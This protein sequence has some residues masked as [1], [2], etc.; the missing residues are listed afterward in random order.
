MNKKETN[1]KTKRTFVFTILSCILIFCIGTI[2]YNHNLIEVRHYN[3]KSEKIGES[4]NNY[5]IVQLSDLH[6]RKFGEDN[7]RVIKY[8]D[9]ENPN[10]VV[11]TGDMVTREEEKYDN[12][13][14]LAK[15]ISEKYETY[16]ILGNHEQGLKSIELKNLLFRVKNETNVS[17]I[18]NTFVEIKREEESINLYG[19]WYSKKYYTDLQ[20]KRLTKEVIEKYI[21]KVDQSKFNM[22][23]THN[24]LNF[25]SYVDAGLD[26]TFTGHVH[27]GIIR[28]PYV[29]G[30]FSPQLTLFPKYDLGLYEKDNK[31]MIVNAG[32]GYGGLKIRMFNPHEISVV[33]L[34]SK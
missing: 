24:P 7:E 18:N 29:G 33:T 17:V 23:I 16:Y 3:I 13:I 28:L 27:G 32:L 14:S 20:N 1:R 9:N 25:E 5:K 8:I 34:N 19:L 22:M 11:F 30:V 6:N 21:G 26:L 4:F 2:I 15:R 31:Y 10:I 12:F